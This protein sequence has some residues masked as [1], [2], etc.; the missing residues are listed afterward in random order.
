MD[1]PTNEACCR[2]GIACTQTVSATLLLMC[3]MVDDARDEELAACDGTQADDGSEDEEDK[4]NCTSRCRRE[5]KL[6]V[7]EVPPESTMFS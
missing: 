4:S 6:R 5:G 3:C 1:A 7:M 2:S